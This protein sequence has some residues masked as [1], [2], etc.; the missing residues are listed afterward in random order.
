MRQHLM[1]MTLLAGAAL[2]APAWADGTEPA[3]GEQAPA[4]VDIEA[5]LAEFKGAVK[6]ADG[7]EDLAKALTTLA[8]AGHH[9]A[10]AALAPYVAH[11]SD[12]VAEAAI[13]GLGTLGAGLE[14][15][16]KP[17]CTK[18]LVALLK[19]DVRQ[20]FRAR[21]AAQNL[22]RIGDERVVA[23][24]LDVIESKSIDVAKAAIVALR[25]LRH[26]AAIEPLIK[27]LVKLE[28]SPPGGGGAGSGTPATWGSG[29]LGDEL[30]ARIT[31]LKQPVLDTLTAITGQRLDASLAWRKWWKA[32]ERTFRVAPLRDAPG[33]DQE[34]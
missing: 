3:K 15:K 26:R 16:H 30:A 13:T 25:T 34:A 9:K 32:N 33:S 2:G 7:P 10:A 19:F 22:E 12:L 23:A 4:P 6:A 5:T 18:P 28:W 17:Y 24:L 21:L 29:D 14:A 31:A 11:R 8:A 20:P 27:A 1:T